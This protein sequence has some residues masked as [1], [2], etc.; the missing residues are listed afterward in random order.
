MSA[1]R[2]EFRFTGW[3]MLAILI[4]FFGVVISVNVT[5]AVM[6]NRS[7]T[8]LVVANSYVASQQ[9][10]EQAEAARKQ[11]ALGWQEALAHDGQAIIITLTDANGHALTG[12]KVTVTIGHPVAEKFDRKLVLSETAPGVYRAAADL[13]QGQWDADVLAEGEAGASFRQ[14]HRFSVKG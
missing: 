11:K 2:S 8:G 6:A 10:N 3:H 4:A 5:L 12:F 9:F 7:W 14:I 13:G 1:A